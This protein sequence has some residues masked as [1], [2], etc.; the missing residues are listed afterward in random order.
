MSEVTPGRW[1]RVDNRILG[2]GG[3]LVAIMPTPV[4]GP[5]E[6]NAALIADAPRLSALAQAGEE[7]VKALK[8]SH[9]V[10]SQAVRRAI[11]DF[12]QARDADQEPGRSGE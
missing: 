5:V 2:H 12:E 10:P 9:I 7:L 11:H 8:R 4:Q 1:Y 6:A 3:T